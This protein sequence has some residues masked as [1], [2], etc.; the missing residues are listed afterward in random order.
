MI[1]MIEYIIKNR[2]Y[3]FY[4]LVVL[5]IIVSSV[6][7][8]W[9]PPESATATSKQDSL[10]IVAYF[11]LFAYIILILL[12][13][14]YKKYDKE[15][16]VWGHRFFKGMYLGFIL[17]TLVF[18]TEL[19][20]GL[21]RVEDLTPDVQSTLLGGI[22]LQGFVAMGEELPFRGYILPEISK[23]YGVWNAVFYSSLFFSV[24]HIPSVLTLGIGKENIIIMLFTI[25]IAEILL[26]LCYLYGGLSMSIGF[27]FTWNFFQY[28]VYSLR[29]D[30]GGILKITPERELITGGAFGPEA[31]LLGLFIVTLALVIVLWWL[32]SR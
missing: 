28:H 31:G 22:V 2:T 16:F 3:I 6:S 1:N 20:S 14:I 21:I 5:V 30:F 8:I 27:H 15:N 26:A 29:Q 4:F 13:I 19:A 7:V 10:P 24:L 32:R 18:L 25:T 23:K 11:P 9:L 12:P 17:I